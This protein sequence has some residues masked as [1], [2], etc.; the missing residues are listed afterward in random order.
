MVISAGKGA[1]ANAARHAERGESL[2]W[3]VRRLEPNH[4]EEIRPATH[5]RKSR[6]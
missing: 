5:I 3:L 2:E 6:V 4:D 1:M